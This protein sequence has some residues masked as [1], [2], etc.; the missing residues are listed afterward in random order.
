MMNIWR[1]APAGLPISAEDV[2]VWL[3]ST[4]L[5]DGQIAFYRGF[6]SANEIARAERFSVTSKYNEFVVSRGLL[7][8][9]LSILT[10]IKA[11]ALELKRGEHNKPYTDELICGKKVAFNV[12]HSQG[13]A[14]VAITL[15]DRLGIDLE[16]ISRE[17]AWEPLARRFLSAFEYRALSEQ[18]EDNRM[19]SFFTCWARKEAFVKALGDGIAYGLKEFDVS[20]DPEEPA[21]L[22]NTRR[23]GREAMTWS[24]QDIPVNEDYVAALA[25]DRPDCRIR[26]WKA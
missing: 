22:L 16:K 18:P 13:L 1:A 25:I 8:S 15:G 21:R 19:R 6:L 11:D 12:S 3:T 26:L 23:Q 9:R 24:M 14:L 5:G 17:V 2:D 4:E 20:V 7:K 10:G